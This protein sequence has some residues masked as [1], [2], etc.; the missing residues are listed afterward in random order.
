MT[1]RQVHLFTCENCKGTFQ[2]S[3]S[4]IELRAESVAN[5]FDPDEPMVSLC[6][7]CYQEVM[8]WW[9]TENAV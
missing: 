1:V 5:G 7:D 4:E 6:D 2:D 9:R 8:T 3:T